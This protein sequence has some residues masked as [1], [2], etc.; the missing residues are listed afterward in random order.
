VGAASRRWQDRRMLW[1]GGISLVDRQPF[2]AMRTSM[3]WLIDPPSPFAPRKSWE[4]LPRGNEAVA[5][6]R[7][8]GTEVPPSG[9]RSLG[10]G[11]PGAS[12][13]AQGG[14]PQGSS[15][16]AS[17]LPFPISS[18]SW[19][20]KRGMRGFADRDWRTRSSRAATAS[21]TPGFIPTTRIW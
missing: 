13:L 20:R 5:G 10:E 1:C 15:V 19:Q 11:A 2:V 8:A 21:C 18:R 4:P 12:L 7:P 9:G 3:R 6:G 14:R 16:Q 17:P